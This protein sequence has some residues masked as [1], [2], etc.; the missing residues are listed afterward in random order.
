M[1]PWKTLG[2]AGLILGLVA[3]SGSN[4]Q[5]DA[6]NDAA[7]DSN[8][9]PDSSSQEDSST[10]DS[11]TPDAAAMGNCGS[12]G[13]TINHCVAGCMT[14]ACYENCVRMSN[15][16]VNC[17]V[18]AQAMCCPTESEAFQQCVAAAS[19]ES[20]AGPACTTQECVLARCSAQSDAFNACLQTQGGM[21]AC[22]AH[23][24]A[25]LGDNTCE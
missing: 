18:G 11:S 16:C 24:A 6:G 22:Q 20:D 5:T 9:Q 14:Q 2:L 17:V 13:R 19:M 12:C 21:P 10:P 23:I 8:T 4:T 7:A 25:C 15:S 3:C 1:A